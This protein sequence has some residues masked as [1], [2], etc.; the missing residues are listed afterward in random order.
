MEICKK[1]IVIGAGAAGMMAA[2]SAADEGAE[3]I[4][5]DKNEKTGKK[6]FITGKGRCNITNA[7]DEDSLIANVVNNPKFLFSAFSAFNSSDMCAFLEKEGLKL[8]VERGN[9]VFPE[10]DH[11]SDV[12]KTLERACKKRGVK[13]ILNEAVSEV[14]NEG[15]IKVI[16]T[17]K[18]KT[19]KCDAVIIATGGFTYASTGS[20][21]DG[22]KFAKA[23][24]HS[25]K[26]LMCGLVPFNIKES[27]CKD[28]M[29]LSLRNVRLTLFVDGKKKYSEQGEMLFTHFGVS[30]PLVLSA[31]EYYAKAMRNFKKKEEPY[32]TIDLKPA[33]SFETLDKRVLKDFDGEK[34]AE[35]KNSLNK[36]LPSGMIETIVK[37]SGIEPTKKVNEI[38]AEER[39][40]L[41]HL[42]KEFRL[43][44]SS[45][46]GSAEAIITSGG[47]NVKEINPKT[48]ESKLSPG[49]YF[50]GEV[51][52][53]DALTGGFNL[54]IAWSTG[55]LAGKNAAI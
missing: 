42:L 41:V 30:G 38:R 10:S 34:N 29:G 36:L 43:N 15:E 28:M 14:L 11:S 12:I 51:I 37:V 27:F 22:Y 50:A 13:I 44:I 35:F 2:I 5:L 40:R 24:G 33:L 3:V 25:I 17:E 7:V 18:K 45:V 8:K 32:I 48:M 53:C 1:I 54:Q 16:K 23:L 46:R 47:V 19:Y 6:L 20:T 55:F 52:D 4:I 21:G 49:V 31:S 39:E 26:P 9:R